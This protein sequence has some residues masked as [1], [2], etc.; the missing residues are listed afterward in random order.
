MIAVNSGVVL[1]LGLALLCPLALSLLYG[2]GSWGSFLIPAAV[3]LCNAETCL[4]GFPKTSIFSE[5][6]PGTIHL[7]TPPRTRKPGPGGPGPKFP[8]GLDDRPTTRFVEGRAC[9][10]PISTIY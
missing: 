10:P 2:D 4:W 1:A 6:A 7:V 3:Q 9:G 8:D 5:A